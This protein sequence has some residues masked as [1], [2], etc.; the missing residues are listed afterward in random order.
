MVFINFWNCC[1]VSILPALGCITLQHILHD[2]SAKYTQLHRKNPWVFQIGY[3]C[4]CMI[5]LTVI[6]NLGAKH[7][8]EQQ[9]EKRKE[10][11]QSP[12]A[13][14]QGQVMS[15]S[16]SRLQDWRRSKTRI[17]CQLAVNH[18]M[19]RRLCSMNT[20]LTVDRLPMPTYLTQSLE[21]RR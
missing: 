13:T 14:P 12:V 21:S 20:W 9:H 19:F 18:H 3:V 11:W 6:Y 1:G 4:I 17:Q 10:R 8:R 15:A 2:T 7:S 5:F 16:V